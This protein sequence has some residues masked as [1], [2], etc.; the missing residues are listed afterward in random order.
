[1]MAPKRLAICR[2][3]VPECAKNNIGRTIGV[4]KEERAPT[5]ISA[6]SAR[7]VENLR[8]KTQ[9]DHGRRRA[10]GRVKVVLRETY[11]TVPRRAEMAA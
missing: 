9:H 2:L 7:W 11:M 4:V 10:H 8:P 6:V 5:A 3:V 1:M